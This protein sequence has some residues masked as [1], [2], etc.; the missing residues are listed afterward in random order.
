MGR[1]CAPLADGEG[2]WDVGRTFPVTN[3]AG[4]A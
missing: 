1:D 3:I 4:S 2:A